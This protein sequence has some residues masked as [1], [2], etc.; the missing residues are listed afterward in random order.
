MSIAYIELTNSCNQNCVFCVRPRDNITKLTNESA[1][2]LITKLRETQT[3]VFTGGEPTIWSGL[4]EMIVHAKRQ[5][6]VSVFIQTNAVRLADKTYT[7]SLKLAGLD[8]ANIALHSHK[9]E[10]SDSL[11]QTPGSFVKTLEGIKNVQDLNIDHSISHIITSKNYKHLLDFVKF[12]QKSFLKPI[13]LSF[14]FV[15]PEISAWDNKWVVPKYSQIEPYLYDALSYCKKQDVP[16]IVEYIPL[17]YLRGFETHSVE[18][19]RG[20]SNEAFKTHWIDT[21]KIRKEDQN[22]IDTL[23]TK[24]KQCRLCWLN[25]ICHG[26]RTNYSAIYGTSELFPVYKKPEEI[27]GS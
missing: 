2:K 25:T 8:K 5:G 18:L 26:V 17:C 16:F 24:G 22:Y 11:T 15:R 6:I 7:E 19:K 13:P 21:K 9:K 12:I 1:K 27:L 20:A 4:Q 10:I 3:L 14:I 23:Q